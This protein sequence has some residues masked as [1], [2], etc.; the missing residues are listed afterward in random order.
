M[1]ARRPDNTFG[2][3]PRNV[4]DSPLGLLRR[5]AVRLAAVSQLV[6]GIFL[7]V[8]LPIT[9]AAQA[10]DPEAQFYKEL[11]A[12]ICGPGGSLPT[13][14]GNTPDS[15]AGQHCCVLSQVPGTTPSLD[16]IAVE[17]V[18]AAHT[19]AGLVAP[20]RLSVLK[21]AARFNPSAPRAPPATSV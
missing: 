1:H 14:D 2:S 8:L 7:S 15:R 19:S 17:I 13:E 18:P 9:A 21:S 11:Y 5:R 16:V 10:N 12:S 20:E 4:T 3:L 6:I